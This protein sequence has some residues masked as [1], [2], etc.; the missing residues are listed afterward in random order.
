ML[1]LAV[2]PPSC[3]QRGP[4][5]KG[6]IPPGESLLPSRAGRPG[7]AL[8]GWAPP[9]L[10]GARSCPVIRPTAQQYIGTPD[11]PICAAPMAVDPPCPSTQIRRFAFVSRSRSVT[12]AR[13]SASAAGIGR[14]C[15]P[16][17][18]TWRRPRYMQRRC[19]WR[20]G[21]GCPGPLSYR[22]VVL[23]SACEA[24]SWTSRSGTPASSA[25]VMKACLSV[26]GVT[27]LVVPARRAVLRTI[28]PAP[29]RSSRRLSVAR[30]TGPTVRSPMA[31]SIAGRSA[32][33]TGW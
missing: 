2:T 33:P 8:P 5:E 28:R 17:R 32:A 29:C 31:R 4:Q 7:C 25:A 24:A 3:A 1:R 14:C 21:P 10:P 30:N 22:I 27:A 15:Q 6:H 20:A 19:R 23:G 11:N 16:V 12:A 9:R 18:T 13:P 26:C